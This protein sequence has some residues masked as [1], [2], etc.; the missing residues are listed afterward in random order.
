MRLDLTAY[1]MR[2]DREKILAAGFDTYL[3][4]PVDVNV[5]RTEIKR[6]LR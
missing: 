5:L 6:L 3:T 2:E 1:A 4:K